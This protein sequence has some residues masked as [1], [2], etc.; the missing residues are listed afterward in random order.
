MP[1][2]VGSEDGI[3]YSFLGKV[4]GEGGIR[5][6]GPIRVTGFQDR[7]LKPLGHLSVARTPLS[8]HFFTLLSSDFLK[9]VS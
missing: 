8:Y 6:H 7:L 2:T 9:I 1:K 4:G 3:G 5:T